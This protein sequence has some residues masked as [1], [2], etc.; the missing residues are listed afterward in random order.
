[1][2]SRR[3][4]K[5]TLFKRNEVRQRFGEMGGDLPYDI[6][7][8]IPYL[9]RQSGGGLLIGNKE[10]DTVVGGTIAWNQ[11]VAIPT[12]NK[13][14]TVNGVVFVDNRDGSYTVSTE[15]GGAT[16]TTDL[17]IGDS[18]SEL[19][20]AVLIAGIPSGGNY[21]TYCLRDGWDGVNKYEDSIKTITN[22]NGRVGAQIR[23][24]SGAVITTPVIFRPQIFDLTQMFGAGKEPATVADFR[25]LFPKPYYAYNAG[26]LMSVQTSAH[27][28]VGFNQFGGDFTV[29]KRWQNGAYSNAPNNKYAATDYLIKC[30]PNTEYCI[31]VPKQSAAIA[32]YMQEFDSNKV[33]IRSR[34]YAETTNKYVTI[35]PNSDAVYISFSM[36]RGTDISPSEVSEVNINLSSS[37]NGEYEPYVKHSYPLDS[38]LTLRG[39]PKLDANNKLY[40]DG[41]EY[42]YD[43]TV[44]R[45]YGI[46][47]MGTLN[48]A[49]SPS[50]SNVFYCDVTGLKP[51]TTA[52][53]ENAICG[54][55]YVGSSVLYLVNMNDKEF[56]TGTTHRIYIKDTAY[57]DAPTFKS[58]VSGNYLVYELDSAT[59]E[60]ADPF[61][62]PQN[63]DPNGTEAYIDTR[64]VPIPVGHE[65]YYQ[66]A[67][68]APLQSLNIL[69]G[70][71][72]VNNH[73]EDDVSDKE[74]LN[75]ILG[76][77]DR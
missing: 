7:D 43:G 14:T 15:P 3:D 44:N 39:I 61:T 11:L 64:D 12:S 46:V 9:Y 17:V 40:Y 25:S 20:H 72:Y 41:D 69:L 30:V 35:T 51:K 65:T 19:G 10:K 74:A 28:M 59:T 16:A 49:L 6:L 68:D 70:G 50:S 47:D 26:E 71:R 73:T 8:Q 22:A 52:V 4:I 5:R 58:S 62:N 66:E 38:S 37:R 45:K 53:A 23:V 56:I 76:G 36:Y 34:T 54:R 13:S 1:M 77:N 29:G 24:F 32:C 42:L 33:W 2:A 60:S 55:T 67:P 27:E 31:S 48:W 75:I 63:V 57:S 21:S 18:Y